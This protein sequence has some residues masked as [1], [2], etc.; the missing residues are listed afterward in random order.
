M[1]IKGV[2]KDGWNSIPNKIAEFLKFFMLV[3]LFYM[4]PILCMKDSSKLEC[5]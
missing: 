1:K 4:K 5:Y 3:F 2:A